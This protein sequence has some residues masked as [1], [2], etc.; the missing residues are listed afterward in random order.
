MTAFGSPP[1]D[2]AMDMFGV[3]TTEGVAN[4]SYALRDNPVEFRQLMDALE[5]R[6]GAEQRRVQEDY[7][8]CY[9]Y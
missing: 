7:N 1:Y 8:K 9:N 6:L 2:E 5:R 4:W 3:G